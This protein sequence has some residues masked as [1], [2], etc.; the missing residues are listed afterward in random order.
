MEQLVPSQRLFEEVVHTALLE[1][2]CTGKQA[3]GFKASAYS[4]F[5]SLSLLPIVEEMQLSNF[6]PL[7]PGCLIMVDSILRRTERANVHGLL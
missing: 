3:Q 1:K 4:G 2:V 7:F 6:L 5:V